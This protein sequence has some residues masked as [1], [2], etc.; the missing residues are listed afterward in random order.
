M[1][2]LV[3]IDWERHELRYASARAAG[4]KL[5]QVRCVVHRW[6]AA[7]E[8]GLGPGSIEAL[9]WTLRQDS[10]S[11]AVGMLSPPR[12][13]L[14][15][16]WFTSPPAEDSE[17]PDVVEAQI[18]AQQSNL[19]DDF[20]FD[21]VALEA[22]PARPRPIAAVA[23]AGG[24]L[25]EYRQLARK[26]GLKKLRVVLRPYAAANL[27]RRMLPAA[28]GATLL[29]APLAEEVDLVVLVDGEPRYWRTIHVPAQPHAAAAEQDLTAQLVRTI[30]VAGQHLP[31]H[32]PIS[33]VALFQGITQDSSWMACIE[34]GLS[35]PVVAIDPASA[36]ES[37]EIADAEPIGKF[38]PLLGMLA[39]EAETIAPAVD[40][41]QPRR[42]ER[43]QRTRRPLLY[44]IA[45]AL[46]ALLAGGWWVG[47]Q[48]D[49]ATQHANRLSQQLKQLR[50][51][52]KEKSVEASTAQRVAAWEQRGVVW[53]D[54]IR[55]LTLK[56]P[57]PQ[58]AVAL[59]LV[60]SPSRAGGAILRLHGKVREPAIVTSF[61]QT[62][63]DEYRDVLSRNFHEESVQRPDADFPWRFE[64][65][66][67][68]LRRP[69]D[70]YQD[71]LRQMPPQPSPG[72]ITRRGPADT[73]TASNQP[74]LRG[75]PSAP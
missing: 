3:A 4:D 47:D 33:Q 62:L 72:V 28:E 45:A 42:P 60:G 17:L 9:S 34:D 21:Y 38:A 1:R 37:L 66:I 75:G 41:L 40:L 39:D 57:A 65:L 25:Q 10:L 55:D 2:Q 44:A 50:A 61:D 14:E 6:Q 67:T 13:H 63:R 22:D 31:E 16:F 64:S 52:V 24:I 27:L 5:R 8:A 36:A 35:L 30:A 32:E 11:A 19:G 18:A 56:F 48:V 74:G 68:T 53:L 43:R 54:E 51:S 29:V 58:D 71:A 7:E 15:T 12:Q 46:L 69:A 73:S 26:V 70:V 23:I 20:V 59:D 49:Q